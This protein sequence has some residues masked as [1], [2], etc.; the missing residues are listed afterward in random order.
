MLQRAVC[1]NVPNRFKSLLKVIPG[2]F[3]FGVAIVS[4]DTQRR[5]KSAH[6]NSRTKEDAQIAELRQRTKALTTAE[7]KDILNIKRRDTIC[8]WVREGKL[9][10]LRDVANGYRFSPQY[11]ADWMEARRV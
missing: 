8:K 3:D 7:V 1:T 10:A 6:G 4:R 11:M 5:C 2:N 9:E